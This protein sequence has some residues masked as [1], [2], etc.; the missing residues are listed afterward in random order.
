MPVRNAMPFLD[1]SIR[2]ILGQTHRALE[3]VIRDDGSTDGST[4]VLRKWAQRDSRVRVYHG[5][6]SLGPVGSSNWIVERT[7]AA[8]VARM[9]ADD[10]SHPDRLRRQLAVLRQHPEAVL[11]GSLWKGIDRH[12]REIRGRDRSRLAWPFPHPPFQHGSILFR[13]EVFDRI[14]GYRAEC[15]YWEDMDLFVRFAAAGRVMVLPDPLYYYRYSRCSTR[16]EA[17]DE[18]VERAAAMMFRC[19]AELDSGRSYDRLL[20]PGP[21]AIDD[22]RTDARAVVA[23]GSVRLWSGGQP[24]ILLR[25]LRRGALR[26]DRTTLWALGWALLGTCSPRL[27]RLSSRVLIRVRDYRA[28]RRFMD[29]TAYEWRQTAVAQQR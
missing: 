4:E 21:A 6:T 17:G 19:L 12:S 20:A 13:R 8:T 29:G 16:R 10:I 18:R 3:L 23:P 15:A 26:C 28:G 2:S 1:E 25:L 11:V 9:D 24:G 14:G 5:E 22:G 7:T 27:L